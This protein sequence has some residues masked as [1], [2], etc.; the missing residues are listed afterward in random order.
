M[1]GCPCPLLCPPEGQ[2]DRTE[3]GQEGDS[4]PDLH[5]RRLEASMVLNQENDS[6]LGEAP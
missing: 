6:G 4:S 3:P 2:P 5:P 1:Q